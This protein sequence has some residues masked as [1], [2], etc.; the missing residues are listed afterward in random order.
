MGLL[1]PRRQLGPF[2]GKEVQ[3]PV[4]LSLNTWQ[5]FF[6]IIVGHYEDQLWQCV[7]L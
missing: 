2:P 1:G 3:Q 6:L 5:K 7:T 4:S